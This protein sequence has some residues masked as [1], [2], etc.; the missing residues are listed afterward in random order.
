MTKL[1]NW[2]TFQGNK[3]FVQV[4]QL[5]LPGCGRIQGTSH[6]VPACSGEAVMKCCSWEVWWNAGHGCVFAAWG[7]VSKS[8]T[9]NQPAE[10]S[11]QQGSLVA[12]KIFWSQ[13]MDECGWCCFVVNQSPARAQAN[14]S[15][16][17]YGGQHRWY[18]CWAVPSQC[19]SPLGNL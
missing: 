16:G 5:C 8:D 9:W 15:R 12:T 2:L 4:T 11:S 14:Q 17:S 19:G 3:N 7:W 13:W 10:S 1:F 6:K 18:N